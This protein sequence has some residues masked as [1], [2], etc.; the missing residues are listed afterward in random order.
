MKVI[1]INSNPGFL[2]GVQPPF[3]EGEVLEVAQSNNPP[4]YYVLKY[5]ESNGWCKSRFIPLPEIDEMELINNKELV[6]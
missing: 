3:V 4:D 1:C 5:L 2:D 6:Q